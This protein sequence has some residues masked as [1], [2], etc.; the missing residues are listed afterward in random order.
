MVLQ[1]L[2]SSHVEMAA[3]FVHPLT[4]RK[5]GVGMIFRQLKV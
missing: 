5:D 2:Q 4:R 3:A 1:H